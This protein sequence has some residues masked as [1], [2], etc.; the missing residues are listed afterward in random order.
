[1]DFDPD[2]NFI[3][4]KNDYKD[5][6]KTYFNIFQNEYRKHLEFENIIVFWDCESTSNNREV[7]HIISIGMV[8]AKMEDGMTK[9]LQKIAEYHTYVDTDYPI[10]PDAFKVHHISKEMI[11]GA[12]RFPQ[13]IENIKEFLTK[14]V[15]HPNQRTI[16]V[17]HNGFKFD[18][19]IL[20][21]NFIQN[22]MTTQDFENFFKDLRCF[23]SLDTLV[24][25]EKVIKNDCPID[26]KTG[27]ISFKLE[28]CYA[29][30]CSND[31]KTGHDKAH[32]ALEDARALFEI[33]SK[34]IVNQQFSLSEF[35]DKKNVV[36]FENFIKDVKTRTGLAYE[37]KEKSL[38]INYSNI[39]HNIVQSFRS[40]ECCHPME[41]LV[42][43]DNERVLLQ[44][45]V[46]CLS[47][48]H[49]VK[50]PF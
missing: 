24:F 42:I 25:L 4:K 9:K 18:N 15:L 33:F 41:E 31:G 49:F 16:F 7:D 29:K 32:D 1:M 34:P 38:H 22:R 47:C 46:L 37:M 28:N 30:Y 3:E 14:K 2:F 27:R 21:C 20:F 17:A 13:A 48:M 5:L 10:S 45:K 6:P 50:K 26:C 43:E 23:G 35:F 19:I 39:H 36:R 44:N 11:K 8:L 40:F 12:P